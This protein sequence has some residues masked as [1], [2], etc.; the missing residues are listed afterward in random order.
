MNFRT[1]PYFSGPPTMTP[2]HIVRGR[3]GLGDV[4]AL[5][6]AIANG[7]APSDTQEVEFVTL[8]NGIVST[9]PY[10]CA[11]PATAA[12]LASLLGGSV[13]SQVPGPG[14]PAPGT[15]PPTCPFIQTATGLV[16]A[17]DLVYY[18]QNSRGM[19]VPGLTDILNSELG[20]GA[21]VSNYNNAVNAAYGSGGPM[22][23][24]I[25]QEALQSAGRMQATP[26]V[27]QGPAPAPEI[28]PASPGQPAANL[29]QPSQSV[30]PGS[31]PLTSAGSTFMP[32]ATPSVMPAVG[33]SPCS[34]A[35]F[36]DTTCYG[37]IGSTTALALGAAL[38]VA[39]FMFGGKH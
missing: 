5:A 20:A 26:I 33:T 21:L 18:V 4:A 28:F 15:T 31:A 34:F 11:T 12:A 29:G 3:L 6:S 17:A 10:K 2:P 14:N 1:R 23:S 39:F 36:S 9:S 38:I 16:N 8:S 24:P 19:S 7:S 25:S 32:A 13:V 37:P 22:P 35:L 30:A 27:Y